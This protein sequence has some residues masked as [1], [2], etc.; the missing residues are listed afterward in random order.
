MNKKISK[1]VS[2]SLIIAVGAISIGMMPVKVEAANTPKT[3]SSTTD[4][5]NVKPGYKLVIN[6]G[7][8]VSTDSTNEKKVI[9]NLKDNN[10]ISKIVVKKYNTTTKKWDD[11]TSNK[12]V[13]ISKD[14]TQLTINASLIGK[15]G[16]S[17]KI[18]IATYDNSA[19][20][21]YSKRHYVVKRLKKVN[22]KKYFSIN[23]A[24]RI[25][26]SENDFKDA[27]K[28][29]KEA[30]KQGTIGLVIR[31]NNGVQKLTVC[32]MNNNN[33]VF[34]EIKFDGKNTSEPVELK[35][36]KNLKVKD[37]N[38]RI[39]LE[40]TDSKGTKHKETVKIS[41]KYYKNPK[42]DKAVE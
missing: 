36:L 21:N 34:D 14:K 15:K 38:Y 28:T 42:I 31:D 25:S 9:F 20:T 35:A 41:A 29:A 26:I 33:K 37:G 13:S 30:L 4:N 10:G 39:M 6:R 2:T 5:S 12:G 1:I 8:R 23:S 22:D 11:I 17:A 3:S 40:T 18:Y 24:P 19:K 7:P 27:T 32:D 16:S